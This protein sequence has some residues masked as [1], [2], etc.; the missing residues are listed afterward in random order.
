M[1]TCGNCGKTLGHGSSGNHW[2]CGDCREGSRISEER[3]G[4][5]PDK[6]PADSQQ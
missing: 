2:I 3:E 5:V 4:D 6:E 1:I